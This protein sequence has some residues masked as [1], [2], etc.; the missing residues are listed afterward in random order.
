M[1]L[2]LAILA[3]LALQSVS[4]AD[5]APA[6]PQPTPD[7]MR[8]MEDAQGARLEVAIRSFTLPSGQQVDLIGV[9]H[10][11][12]DAYY[13]VLN[14]RFEAYDCVLFELVGNPQRLTE[15][16]PPVL[17]QEYERQY[18][19]EL[20]IS[21]LQLAAGRYLNLAFQLG[22]IDYTKRNMVHADVST[23][24]FAQMQ[25]DRGETM[26]TLLLRAMNAQF[27]AG[28]NTAAMDQLNTFALLRIL[29][30]PDSAAQLKKALARVFDQAE[31]LTQLVEG[32]DGTAVLSGRNAVVVQKLQ[33]V[34]AN[35]KHRRSAVFY[36]G[37][38][39]P[40]IEAALI[41]KLHAKVTG[42]EWLAAWTMP[43]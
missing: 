33:E 7:Y 35:G 28:T 23:A 3:S 21:T 40:G 1:N 6:D 36:G 18:G 24:Q 13:Q 11:A 16:P 15:T 32:A 2:P 10:I 5:E 22:A 31:S 20:S 29:L 39:M 38:H 43:N 12:D 4:L 25:R 26:L 8:Y 37:G 19:N 30:S 9:V 42:E 14:R 34:L 17:R 27:S 41:G